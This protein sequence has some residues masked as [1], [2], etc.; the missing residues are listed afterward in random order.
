MFCGL[1]GF[2]ELLQKS[3]KKR[4]NNKDKLVEGNFVFPYDLHFQKKIFKL[5]EIRK[6]GSQ[7][8]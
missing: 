8:L 3:P 4:I 7:I 1:L 6:I 2:Q 5:S